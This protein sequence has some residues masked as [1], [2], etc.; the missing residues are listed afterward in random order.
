MIKTNG[1]HGISVGKAN[2]GASATVEATEFVAVDDD[3]PEAP[4]PSTA[5][6]FGNSPL[7]VT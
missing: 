2:S 3:V 5:A 4:M 1:I 7:I 6:Y